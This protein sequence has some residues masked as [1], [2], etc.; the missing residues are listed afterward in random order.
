[1]DICHYICQILFC[2]LC[3]KIHK[4][5]VS[6]NSLLVTEK[7]SQFL[8]EDIQ[9]AD[10]TSEAIFPTREMGRAAFCVKDS[11]VLA[12]LTLIKATYAILDPSVSVQLLRKDGDLVTAPETIAFVEGPVRS[13]LTGERVILNLLQRMSGIASVTNQAVRALQS[14]CTKIADTRKTTPGLRLFEKYAVTCGGGVNHRHGLYDGVM[15]KDNHIAFCGSI[16]AAVRKVRE[17][18][19]PMVKIEVETETKEQV[20]EAVR[21]EVDI[22]MFDN[23]T[24]DE[25]STLRKLVPKHFLTEASGGI[26]LETLPA[27]RD[28]GVDFISLGFLTHSAPA[29]DISLIFE[30][31]L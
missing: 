11:G 28:T 25:I 15:I 14:E 4:G 19:G 17:T 24:P 1:M 26:T 27:Y 12:G 22:I 7:L 18:V 30:G 9:G 31:G 21:C 29:L 16:S 13:I 6:L 10:L 23:R 2:N 20:E 8:K 3:E 5:G